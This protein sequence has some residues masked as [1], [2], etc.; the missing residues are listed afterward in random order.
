MGISIVIPS[1]EGREL[2]EALFAS[3]GCVEFAE[4]DELIVVDGCSKDGTAEF[5]RE[6]AEE[7]SLSIKLVPLYGNFGFSGNVNAGLKETNPANDVVIMNNDVVISDPEVFKVMAAAMKED[8]WLGVLSP[9]VLLRTGRIQADGGYLLPFS[10]D[11][12][13]R[14]GGEKWMGQ[15]PGVR[16]SQ[17]VPFVCA[18]VRRAC[19]DV[20][21]LL[22]EA[23]FAYFEDVDFCLR[24]KRAGWKVA[25]T[26]ETSITHLGP[27][28][29]S[30][31][32]TDVKALYRESKA[33]F[34]EEWR[35]YLFA[36]W[37]HSVVWVGELGFATGYGVWSRHAM[38]ACLDAGILTHYQ[39]ARM[40]VHTDHKS[41]EASTRDCQLHGGSPD[42]VQIMIEHADRFP[43]NSGRYRV[44]WTMC[45]VEPWPPG[46]VE[47][48]AWVD[49]VWVPTD[50]ERRLLLAS[51]IER[52]VHV[53]PLGVDPGRF[54]PEIGAWPDKPE[55]DFLFV[56]CFLWGVRKNPDLLITAFREEF[57]RSESVA[58]FIKT[59]TK[60]KGHVLAYET[61]WWMRET[62]PLV[63]ITSDSIVD[64][65]MAGL[66][67]MGDCFVLPT[68]G[69]GWCLPGLEALAT[70]CPVIITDYGAP[71]EWGRDGQG[72]ALPGMHFIEKTMIDCR[73]DIPAFAG[74]SW[75]KPDV[76]HLRKQ[77]RDAFEN[78]DEWKAGA[79][80]GSAI[81]REKLNWERTAERIKARLEAIG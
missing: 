53:M 67:A 75:A 47:G 12:A 11:G 56:A 8:G 59:G 23:Y 17:Y 28:T 73:A 68:S 37:E 39:P 50:R 14:C 19:L 49:E 3:F 76:A 43:R 52:P 45:E 15:Y 9:L 51:G 5:V 30:R 44:G 27:A 42:M 16:E 58:L 74:R 41:P 80:E 57:D 25:S 29:T 81:V 18:M 48:C 66:Y 78:R 38:K 10:H 64:A 31:A 26:T 79:L 54:H 71:A 22:D 21:G 40:A 13:H 6:V 32:V 46:W 60:E 70:G 24:A 72:K 20:V 33:T 34:E 35:D 36:E 7:S 2:L 55:F 65:D 61:R 1:Y 77:M 69:E 62:G 63:V 4:D